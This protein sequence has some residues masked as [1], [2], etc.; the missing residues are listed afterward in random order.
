MDIFNLNGPKCNYEGKGNINGEPE[1]TGS[2]PLG[3][4]VVVVRI[5]HEGSGQFEQ[6]VVRFRDPSESRTIAARAASGLTARGTL[7]GIVGGAIGAVTGT[8]GSLANEIFGSG[9]WTTGRITGQFNERIYVCRVA[10][11]SYADLKPGD[12]QLEVKSEARWTCEFIQ[13]SLGQSTGLLTDEDEE[14][15]GGQLAEPGVYVLGPRTSGRR[16]VSVNIRHT[17]ADDFSISAFSVD[18]THHCEVYTEKGQFYV[19]DKQTDIRPGKEYILRVAAG[20][21]WNVEFKEGY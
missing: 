6:K 15:T 8:A 12:Y 7:G 5:G 10:D 20:G 3:R 21:Q 2:F 14:G 18:G 16:P 4:G 11:D 1:T 9:S 17:G 13:P 19:E